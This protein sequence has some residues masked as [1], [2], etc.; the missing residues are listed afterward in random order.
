MSTLQ[1][2]SLADA[3]TRTF[4]IM[5]PALAHVLKKGEAD[6][7][8]RKIDPQIF[9]NARLAPDMLPLIAQVR[10]AAD[11]AK[12][13]VFRLAGQ[14]VPK[15]EDNETSFGELQARI[16]RMIEM[17]SAVP[18]SAFEGREGATIVLPSRN[19]DRTFSALDYLFGYALPN[20]HFH[21]VTAYAILRHNGV[22]LGKSDYFGRQG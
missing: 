12:S 17:I 18:A 1:G 20:F 8:A 6:A 16:A 3:A 5:L 19:G 9:L 13:A 15:V 7:I 4:K 22:V 10:I 2:I 21:V 11:T 14:E